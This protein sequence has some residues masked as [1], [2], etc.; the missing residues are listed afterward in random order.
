[1]RL[2]DEEILRISQALAIVADPPQSMRGDAQFLLAAL[3]T[4]R[5]YAVELQNAAVDVSGGSQP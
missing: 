4:V 3:E 1:M 5:I 2:S